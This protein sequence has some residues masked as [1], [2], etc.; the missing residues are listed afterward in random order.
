MLLIWEVTI[1][2]VLPDNKIRAAVAQ[3]ERALPQHE[4]HRPFETIQQWLFR[5]RKSKDIV[6]I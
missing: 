5:L 3:W 2:Q 4:P 6:S 1:Q